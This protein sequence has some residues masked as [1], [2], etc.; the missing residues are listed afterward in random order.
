MPH[1]YDRPMRLLVTG[2]GRCGTTWLARALTAA[3]T[4][5]THEEYWNWDRHGEGPWTAEVA[6]PAAPYTPVPNTYLV[7]LVRHP[8]ATIR[9]RASWGTFAD[10]PSDTRRYRLGQWVEREFP[11]IAAGR[12]PLEK[13]ALHWVEWNRLVKGADEFLRLEDIT[14]DDVTRLARV[15]NPGAEARDLSPAVNAA[16]QLIDDL[17]WEDVAGVPGLLDLAA[18]Y[19]YR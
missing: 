3:G 2:A 15:V 13:A 11:A 5:C 9:S 7:H 6:W 8:L 1:H 18:D 10:T 17:T 16:P 14:P 4:P 19:G 12:T